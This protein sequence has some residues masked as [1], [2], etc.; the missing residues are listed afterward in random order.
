MS[1]A[2]SLAS[3]AQAFQATVSLGQRTDAKALLTM[4]SGQTKRS[5]FLDNRAGSATTKLAVGALAILVASLVVGD[6]L[7]RR[8]QN[9]GLSKI[10][11]ARNNSV[12]RNRE[13]DPTPTAAIKGPGRTPCGESVE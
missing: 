7:A 1:A 2:E 3:F 8:A 12:F 4:K 10:D 9:H 13:V 5:D 11:F 6:E